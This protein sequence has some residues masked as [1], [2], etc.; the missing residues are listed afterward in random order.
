V[1]AAKDRGKPKDLTIDPTTIKMIERSKEMNIDTIFDWA[2][3]MKACNI[4]IQGTCCKNCAHGSCRLLLSKSVIEGND[5]RKGLCGA[6]SE[7]LASRN[8]ARMV[9]AGSAV[10][11]D[12]G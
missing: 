3:T 12:H 6:M 5:T 8:F 7:T 11:S 4:G 1:A 10:H 9:V 2:Q